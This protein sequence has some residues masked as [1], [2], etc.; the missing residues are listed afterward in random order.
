MDKPEQSSQKAGA[1]NTGAPKPNEQKMI[2]R[3]VTGLAGA[4]FEGIEAVG[5]G[6][7]ALWNFNKSVLNTVGQATEPLR[8]PLDAL[9]VTELVQRPVEAVAH[10]VEETV[11]RMEQ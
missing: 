11:A 9:G 2:E 3:T 4:A 1:Q 5:G 10:N 7:T 8:K 6:I